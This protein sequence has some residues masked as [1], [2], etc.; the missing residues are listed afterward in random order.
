MPVFNQLHYTRQ[1]LESLAGVGIPSG[2]VVV[3]D[4]ASSDGTRDFLASTPGLRVV[5]NDTNRGCSSAWNQGVETA[6]AAAA[7]WIVVINNDVLVGQGFLGGL[8]GFAT[9]NGADIVHPAT[10]EGEQ[11]YDFPSLAAG[12]VEKMSGFSRPDD[13]GGDCFLVSRRVFESVGLFDTSFGL[14]GFEDVD[15]FRRARKAGFHRAITGAAF[16]HHFGSV[17]QRAVKA[18]AGIARHARL[19][20]QNAYRR[21]HG[22][23]W[24]RRR[25]EKL[26]GAIRTSTCIREESR[27]TGWSLRMRRAGGLWELR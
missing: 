7:D 1:C 19:A 9:R 24:F 5:S 25:V 21:K 16:L 20:D 18:S 8:L 26:Q 4:N 12:F 3:V 2:D 15:F 22:L 14:A 11:D 10:A 23:N 17:T 27:T 13:G 6:L